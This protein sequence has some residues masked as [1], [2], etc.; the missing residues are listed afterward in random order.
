MLRFLLTI[1]LA[2]IIS[3]AHGQYILSP[4]NDE[5]TSLVISHYT[6]Q[7][8]VASYG[9][10][11]G[12]E[13][14][15]EL[16]S[17]LNANTENWKRK[18]YD[19]W[20]MK[21][22]KNEHLFEVHQDDF[23]LQG[24]AAFNFEG[25][26]YTDEQG[27]RAYT[28]TR[29]YVFNG[30]IGKRIFFRTTF[31]ENQ[32]IFPNYMDSVVSSKGDFNEKGGSNF[33]SRGSVP[34]YGRWKS[35]TRYKS[36]YDYDYTLAT[37][38]FGIVLNKFT[39]AQFGHE[40]H[41]V[42]H[43]HRSLFLSDAS[44]PFPFLKLQVGLLKNRITYTTTY[45]VLQSLDRITDIGYANKENMFRRLGAR[46]HYLSFYP[47][48]WFSFGLFDGTTWNWRKNSL[49]GSAE[50][51]SPH[52]WLYSGIGIRNHITGANGQVTLLKMLQGYGQYAINLG[53]R[54]QAAQVGLRIIHPIPN[55]M[56]Q[57]EY[58]KI[59]QGFYYHSVDSSNSTIVSDEVL[60]AG[61]NALDYY[62][63]NDLILGH[64]I[65]VALDEV[66][67]KMN[68]RIRDV[69]VNASVTYIQLNSVTNPGTIQNMKAE[70]GYILNTK[71]NAQIVAGLIYR[72]ESRV[73]TQGMTTNFPF[74]AFR[75]NI[76]NRYTD[77]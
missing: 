52:G 6:K 3:I 26:T 62:Q 34:G 15:V 73:S 61:T 69:F 51:Y 12:L 31:F 4:L 49:A 45:A 76:F 72:R 23:H 7:G 33:L 68:Y 2:A 29:G 19:S 47:A 64:P 67:F 53:S 46:F 57:V 60:Q 75:T 65:G 36:S 35:F 11:P 58:N 63:H 22:L 14:M 28:N 48:G 44:S 21:K 1:S 20:L 9:M 74:I 8:E 16:D 55:L 71:S 41:F 70:F 56:L 24:D 39:Y 27:R 5:Q 37:G 54:G 50:Y 66:L 38:S 17:I 40:K 59:G 42:G 32:S 18:T 30:A 43:G 25:S 13:Q 77:F 10:R